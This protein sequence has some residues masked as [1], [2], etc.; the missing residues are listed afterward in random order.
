M[1][2]ELYT[3]LYL[4]KLLN[5]INTHHKNDHIIWSDI[6][7]CHYASTVPLKSSVNFIASNV[8]LLDALE[9]LIYAIFCRLFHFN[10]YH[11]VDVIK[12]FTPFYVILQIF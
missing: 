11:F 12:N 9:T 10:V 5:F 6:A 8:A 2:S 1:D 7:S 4:P 3:Q